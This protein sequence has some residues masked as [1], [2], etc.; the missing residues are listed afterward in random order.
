VYS[1][2]EILEATNAILNKGLST[3]TQVKSEVNKNIE[4]NIKLNFSE[5]NQLNSALSSLTKQFIQS[6]TNSLTGKIFKN[7]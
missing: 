5:I 2:E 3:N 4:K 1:I 6:S 7:N